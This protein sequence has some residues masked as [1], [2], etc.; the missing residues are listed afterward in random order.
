MWSPM[1]NANGARNPF[2]ENMEKVQ[3][4]GIVFA[5]ADQKIKAIGV[6]QKRAYSAPKPTSFESTSNNW[7]NIGWLVEVEFSQLDVPVVPKENLSLIG[8]FLTTKAAPL[9]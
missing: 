3:P 5:Y 1:K 9:D 7:S 6:A 8:Q 4:G 2:Y